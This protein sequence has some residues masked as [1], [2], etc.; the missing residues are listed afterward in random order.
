MVR[1]KPIQ[2]S[3]REPYKFL[4]NLNK[5]KLSDASTESRM[6]IGQQLPFNNKWM[7]LRLQNHNHRPFQQK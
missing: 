4:K 6:L 3:V 2:S 5:T 7:S 1:H